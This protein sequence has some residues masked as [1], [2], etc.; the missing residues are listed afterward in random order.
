[1]FLNSGF[2]RTEEEVEKNAPFPFGPDDGMR[3]CYRDA[4]ADDDDNDGYEI[5]AV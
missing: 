3:L 5:D 4:R 2:E 1:M